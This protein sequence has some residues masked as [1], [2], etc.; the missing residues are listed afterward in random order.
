[1]GS[2]PKIV[3]NIGI[4]MFSAK[5]ADLHAID[6]QYLPVIREPSPIKYP[7]KYAKDLDNILGRKHD[8]I[9]F[10]C[11]ELNS[12]Y[13]SLILPI[14]IEVP[15][16]SINDLRISVITHLIIPHIYYNFVSQV[17]MVGIATAAMFINKWPRG[18]NMTELVKKALKRF[19]KRFSGSEGLEKELI[20]LS[21]E[22]VKI[23][24]KK[25]SSFI[26]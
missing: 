19:R 10:P 24:K 17:P 5:L 15:I 20:P 23:R 4:I 22:E 25:K 8:L 11:L 2:I 3:A 26:F 12:M 21:G 14:L 13:T 16:F 1:L 9:P 18:L 7:T 6:A